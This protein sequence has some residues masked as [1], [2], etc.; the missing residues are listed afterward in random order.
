MKKFIGIALVAGSILFTSSLY[1]QSLDGV[2][3]GIKNGNAVQVT[4]NAGANFSLTI[5]D[6]SNNYSKTEAQQAIKDFLPRT[7]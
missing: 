3:A 4:D 7:A 1:A 2:V 5:M 6:K